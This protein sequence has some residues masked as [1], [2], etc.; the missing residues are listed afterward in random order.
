MEQNGLKLL[1]FILMN[2]SGEEAIFRYA[3][4]SLT[5]LTPAPVITKSMNTNSADKSEDSLVL[6]LTFTV[7]GKEIRANRAK[8][9][10]S[11][12]VFAAMLEGHYS[13][14]KSCNIHISDA[15]FHSFNLI[16]QCIHNSSN[17]ADS[18]EEIQNKHDKEDTLDILLEALSLCDRYNLDEL[19]YAICD[20]VSNQ[21]VEPS[22]VDYI[23][24]FSVMHNCEILAVE[25]M[26]YILSESMDAKQRLLCFDILAHGYASTA[27]LDLFFNTLESNI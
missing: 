4:Q 9:A 25:C 19:Q 20:L 24:D 5:W 15:S 8:T 12:E 23:L 27:A 3:T 17:L 11:S 6:D 13:E 22:S 14:S 1:K 21:C 18:V 2:H 10:S 26:H 7:K 16:V